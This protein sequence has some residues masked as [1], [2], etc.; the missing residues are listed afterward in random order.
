MLYATT[1]LFGVIDPYGNLERLPRIFQAL[2]NFIP[3]T[4]SVNAL[5]HAIS[6][7]YVGHYMTFM[8]VLIF[9]GVISFLLT[10]LG[11][12]R[13]EVVSEDEETFRPLIIPH[14]VLG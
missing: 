7:A 2:H 14:S 12:K 4:Q 13:W 3:V 8:T 1:Y 11:R 5:R 10:L 9:M 6:G